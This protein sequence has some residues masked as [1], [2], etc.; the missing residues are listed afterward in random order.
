MKIKTL[1]LLGALAILVASCAK[2]DNR[3]TGYGELS[4]QL[5][6][7]YE[8]IPASKASAASHSKA[9]NVLPDVDNFSL[10][11][12]KEDG[13]Y[14]KEWDKVSEFPQES[15]FPTGNYTMKAWYG[16][17][18]NEGFDSPYYE[19]TARLSIRENELSHADI[20]CYLANVKLT[21]EYTEAFKKYFTD[22]S[23]TVHSEG[24]QFIEFIK[25]EERAAYVK[26]GNI[27]ILVKLTKQNGISSTFEPTAITGA[28]GRQHY[29]IKLDVNEGN[30]GGDILS[31][32]FDDTT[33]EE[34]IQIDLSDEVMTAPAPFFTLTGF[35]SGVMQEIKENNYASASTVSS[36]L[37]ARGGIKSCTLTTSSAVLT[38]QGWPAEIDLTKATEQQKAALAKFGLKLKGLT[39]NV[40]KMAV[41]D[42]TE[43][44]PFLQLQNGES[45]HVF[46]LVAKDNLGKVNDP[47]SLNIRSLEAAFSL[48]EPTPVAVGSTSA[49]IPLTLDGDI[50]KL[51]ISYM[52]DFGS[53][54]DCSSLSVV[55]NTGNQYE[56]R[57]D[58]QAGNTPKRVK[59]SYMN[60]KKVSNEVILK[61][62]IPEYSLAT[63]TEDSWA[64][65]VNIKITTDSE[66]E[67]I[68]NKYLTIYSKTGTANWTKATTVKNG[69]TITVTGLTPATAYSFKGTCTDGVNNTIF[70]PE[71]TATTETAPNLPNGSFEN[72][73][74]WLSKEINLGGKY[75]DIS[76]SWSAIYDKTTLSSQNPDGWA[77]V[78]IKTVP[79]GASNS[80]FMVPSTL[81]AEGS[82]GKGA[83]IRSVAWD[84]NG[85]DPDRAY[86]K[87]GKNSPKS[88]AMRSA[89][90]LFLGSYTCT[91]SGNGISGETYTEGYEFTSRPSQLTGMYSYTAKG[92]DTNGTVHVTVE[93]RDGGT[94]T[95]L[96]EKQMALNPV[97][98]F[99][100]F[101]VPLDYTNT[102]LKATHIKVMFT[103][104]N[105]SS[106]NQAD[107][108]SNIQTS[109]NDAVNTCTSTGS[110]L[111]IDD[112]TFDYK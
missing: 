69:T 54:I 47:V 79:S 26:P 61:V 68:I 58:I 93:N 20:T 40:D 5:S 25:G 91:H 108:T 43:V 38:S 46:T 27:S 6:A 34:P 89:G 65:K 12:T 9:E 41:I 112:L 32:S 107:E 106:Y 7:D 63:S 96:A 85:S 99:T 94:T 53:W 55:S 50:S 11:I 77:T 35:E 44:I 36:F 104:S 103:S 23:T 78:N 66:Y 59:A 86:S 48:H 22:Y 28:A 70:S 29:R 24:G 42:F 60:G 81:Q 74:E 52:S 18:D 90:K 100:K 84:N 37:T 64:T 16:D 76:I 101:T 97:S 17:K 14:S 82:N 88:I 105:K 33:T 92:E 3:M 8:A 67:N 13:S 56:I 98:S 80:W 10:S 51:K 31:I 57:A 39:G 95:V 4:F 62:I 72:W 111:C 1:S 73:T 83:L 102:K 15:K 45:D 109:N 30:V 71:I 75:S 110:E 2:D 49:V 19:G 21:V 87:S